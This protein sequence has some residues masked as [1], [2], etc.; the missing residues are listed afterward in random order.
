MQQDMRVTAM[1]ASE[2]GEEWVRTLAHHDAAISNLSGRMT[3]VE[4]NL[5]G[6]QTDVT[7]GFTDLGSKIEKI[8][9]KPSFEAS[10]VLGI[11]KDA[12][13]LIGAAVAAIIWVTTGQFSGTVARQD[14]T[15]KL[16]ERRLTTLEGRVDEKI[17][18]LSRVEV[19]KR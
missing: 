15:N 13:V 10:S 19:G 1:T 4:A 12:A 9:A 2:R 16:T 18:W 5:K 6:L 14:E 8:A 17:G 11:V 3:G 7:H